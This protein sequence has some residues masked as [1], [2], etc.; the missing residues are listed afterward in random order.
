MEKRV[1]KSGTDF[2]LGMQHFYRYFN[3]FV[4]YK[5]DFK[6]YRN[7]STIRIEYG[8]KSWRFVDYTGVAGKGFHLC[9]FVA[10]DAREY[11]KN[12]AMAT[13]VVK[14]T[15]DLEIQ[16]ANLAGLAKYVGQQIYCVDVDDCYWDTAYK[17]GVISYNTY[18][19]GLRKKEWKTGRNA[20]IGALNKIMVVTE[21]ING[22]QVKTEPI[23]ADEGVAVIRNNIIYNVHNIF[24]TILKRLGDDWLMYF[25]DCVYVPYE[26]IAG[27]RAYF[28]GLGYQTKV[29]TYQL[30]E[31]NVK[32]AKVLWHD[33][34]K[35]RAK[36]FT[37]CGRQLSLERIPSFEQDLVKVGGL[38]ENTEFLAGKTDTVAPVE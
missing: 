11:V 21:Y 38:G 16:K 34:S 22:Q 7:G 14:P 18:M 28:T 8:E 9:K 1:N 31:V 35:N 30:D 10:N 17:M 26:Q 2:T 32:T 23:K 6:L 25:T 24:L 15:M 5:K 3:D 29:S 13:A 12:N 33:Y 20:S 19:R 27:V 36:D 37:F 4:E